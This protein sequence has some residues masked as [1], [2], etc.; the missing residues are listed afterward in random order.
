MTSIKEWQDSM[1]EVG[2][3]DEAVDLID[4]DDIKRWNAD[5]KMDPKKFKSALAM[6]VTSDTMKNHL[7]CDNVWLKGFAETLQD[8]AA[9]HRLQ[10]TIQADN[11]GDSHAAK[12]DRP[13]EDFNMPLSFWCNLGSVFFKGQKKH[14]ATVFTFLIEPKLGIPAW[15]GCVSGYPGIRVGASS[16]ASGR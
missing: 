10:E 14:T 5:K 7:F 3:W 1:R 4:E 11:P 8:K 16:S 6:T 15:F 12:V 13:R 9:K 2:G